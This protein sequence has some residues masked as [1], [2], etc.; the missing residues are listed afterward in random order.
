[1]LDKWDG[2]VMMNQHQWVEG[3]L[4]YYKQHDIQI[5]DP[6]EGR[7]EDAHYPLPRSMGDSTVKLLHDHHQI[8]GVLQ[9]EEV[10]RC[11]FYSGDVIRA[12]RRLKLPQPIHN[13]ISSLRIKWDAH[14]AS[15]SGFCTS[16]DRQGERGKKGGYTTKSRGVGIFGVPANLHSQNSK[17]GIKNTNSQKW[18]CLE[19]GWISNSGGVGHHMKARGFSH[20]VLLTTDEFNEIKDLPLMQRLLAW[21]TY[22]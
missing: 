18:M 19:D 17:I 10:G 14:R 7:W 13:Y 22:T 21:G 6:N 4:N 2:W 8:Q 11:C 20:R 12:L 15:N 3:C 5:G 9:S 16:L 1:M